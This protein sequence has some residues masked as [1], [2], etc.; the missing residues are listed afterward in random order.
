MGY[1]CR[2]VE[3]LREALSKIGESRWEYTAD[4][5]RRIAR[6]ALA[7]PT[8][9]CDDCGGSG[10]V[11]LNPAWPG[12]TDPYSEKC[13]TCSGTGDDPACLITGIR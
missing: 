7:T 3:R 8:L 11:V 2:E 5:Y 6:E 13:A 9:K 10:E 12:G 4:V 1:R